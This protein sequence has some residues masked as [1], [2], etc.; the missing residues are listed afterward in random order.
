MPLDPFRSFPGEKLT[1]NARVHR[2]GPDR[3]AKWRVVVRERVVGCAAYA[4]GVTDCETAFSRWGW[5][6]T[7]GRELDSAAESLVRV[8]EAVSKLFPMAGR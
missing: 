2:H 7:A 5:L 4:E 6:R 1:W 3:L 8:S